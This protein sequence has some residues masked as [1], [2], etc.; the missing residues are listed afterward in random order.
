MTSPPL[1]LVVEDESNSRELV[2]KILQHSG[3]SVISA[4]NGQKCLEVLETETPDLIVMD[5][6]MPFLDGWETTRIIKSKPH[7]AHI[8]VIA[9]TAHAMVEEKRRAI[10]SGCNEYLTKPYRPAELVTLVKSL[11]NKE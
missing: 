3:Y 11:L 7:L 4:V 5:L 9:V 8:P 6:S 1:I 2:E 10:D